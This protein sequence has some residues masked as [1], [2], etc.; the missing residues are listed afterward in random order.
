MAAPTFVA[1]S[2]GDT[3]ATGVWTATCHAPGAAG[4]LILFHV[5]QD[6]TT[7]V[8]ATTFTNIENIAGTDSAMNLVTA[9][10]VGSP[11]AGQHVFWLGRSL[12][13]SAPTI[14]GTNGGGGDLYWR[15][16]EFQDVSTGTTVATVIENSTGEFSSGSGTSGT[17]ADVDVVTMGTDRLA[18]NLVA[19]NDDNAVAAFTGMTG[20]TW[21]EA[22]AEYATATG[23]DGC[24]QLQTA[25]MASA[26]TIGGG[27]ATN[28]DAADGW[29]VFGF[30][31]IGT[32][33]PVTEAE[34]RERT[35]M[36]KQ[37][38]YPPAHTNLGR[39]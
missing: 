24:I 31:L 33:P 30:A 29:G 28:P 13:T 3:D 36:L 37:M 14:D 18:V 7:G 25:A 4:R 35:Q 21:G 9:G 16:Y 8:S 38:A 1:A 26:G 22:V 19:I 20:G 27:T 2:T 12:S 39:S 32:T 34:T 10:T 17:I 23:T 6:A 5:F 15:F 11:S